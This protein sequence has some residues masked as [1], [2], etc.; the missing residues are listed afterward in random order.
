MDKSP[1]VTRRRRSPCP[2]STGLGR[3]SS[4]RPDELDGELHRGHGHGS[5]AHGEEGRRAGALALGALD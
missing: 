2:T 5:G 3:S 1:V 4:R